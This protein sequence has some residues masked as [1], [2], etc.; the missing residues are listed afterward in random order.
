MGESQQHDLKETITTQTNSPRAHTEQSKHDDSQHVPSCLCKA[1]TGCVPRPRTLRSETSD[2]VVHARLPIS[3]LTGCPSV[4]TIDSP[5]G[6]KEQEGHAGQEI[7]D[8]TE[9]QAH[10]DGDP[11][12]HDVA[13]A[14]HDDG[15][16]GGGWV[17]GGRKANVFLS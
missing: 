13:Q 8:A 3:E 17:L 16:C 1:A 12:H 11:R 4:R 10:A 6:A 2:R 7:L 14:E 9:P 5:V 15:P